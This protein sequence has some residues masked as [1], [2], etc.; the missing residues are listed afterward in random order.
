MR[1]P[2]QTLVVCFSGHVWHTQTFGYEHVRSCLLWSLCL[3]ILAYSMNWID[4]IIGAEYRCTSLPKSYGSNIGHREYRYS[5]IVLEPLM[6]FT[7]DKGIWLVVWNISYFFHSILGIIIPTDFHIFQRGRYTTNQVWSSM[8]I[9]SSNLLKG[10]WDGPM[11]AD[12]L[13]S[14]KWNGYVREKT[15][16]TYIHTYIEYNI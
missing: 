4:F 16:H 3:W 5:I 8:Y 10:G 11:G 9:I 1:L 7:T 12:S 14:V 2:S 13:Q 15:T 6:L